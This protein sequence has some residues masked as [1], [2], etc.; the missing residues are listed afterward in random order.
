MSVQ[1]L[2]VN[3]ATSSG[4]QGGAAD[5]LVLGRTGVAETPS[6][7]T[8]HMHNKSTNSKKLNL[9]NKHDCTMGVITDI[10]ET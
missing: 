5:V 6:L 1:G 9:Q 3:M 8:K 10:S 7:Y 2:D 4:A